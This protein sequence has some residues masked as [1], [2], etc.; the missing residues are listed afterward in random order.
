MKELQGWKVIEVNVGL[1]R[2]ATRRGQY[3]FSRALSRDL[4]RRPE[5]RPVYPSLPT[6]ADFRGDSKK[7]LKKMPKNKVYIL[8]SLDACFPCSFLYKKYRFL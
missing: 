5:S 3:R 2:D 4:G 6:A 7:N 8:T 1:G